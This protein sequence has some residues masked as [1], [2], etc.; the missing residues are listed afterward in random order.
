LTIFHGFQRKIESASEALD[1]E[2]QLQE[3]LR[4]SLLEHDMTEKLV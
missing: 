1:E 2:K 4:L 3:A